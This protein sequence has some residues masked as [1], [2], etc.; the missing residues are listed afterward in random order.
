[1]KKAVEEAVEVVKEAVKGAANNL[2]S[3]QDDLR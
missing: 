3:P 2:G 1:V